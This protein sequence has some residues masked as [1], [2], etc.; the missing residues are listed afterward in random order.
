VPNP[1]ISEHD[2]EW[3]RSALELAGA[4]DHPAVSPNPRVGAVLVRDGRRIGAAAHERLGDLHAETAALADCRARGEEPRGATLYLTLEPCA[5]HGRQPPCTD[6]IRAAGIARVVIASDD[7]SPH[8]HGRGP[9][10]LAA[11][12]VEVAWAGGEESERARRLNQPFRKRARTG[13]PYVTFKSAVSLDGRTAT[14]TGDSQW[15]SGPESRFMGH[16]TRHQVD[17]IGVGIGTALADDPLLTTRAF[18]AQRQPTRVVFDSEARLPLSSRLVETAREVPL[19][20]IAA[21]RAPADRIAA[22][23]RAGAEVLALRGDPIERVRRG[24]QELGSRGVAALLLEGGP[25]LAGSFNDAGEID[26]LSLYVA[27]LL[28]GGT[29]ARPVIGGVGAGSLEAARRALRVEWQAELGG[30]LNVSAILREW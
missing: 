28:I 2:R 18:E 9:S 13:R 29:E 10:L 12:G 25:T 20:V 1:A 5:H 30:D 21:D 14:R 3:L 27:P 22:L 7:P 24:L 6:A 11:A 16:V 26:A 19:V 4:V 15:I 8:A 23:E 17:A